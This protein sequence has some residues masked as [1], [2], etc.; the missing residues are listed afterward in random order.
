MEEEEE[1][2]VEAEKILKEIMTE[3]LQIW[4]EI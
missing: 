1:K 4:Q 2:E 3:T